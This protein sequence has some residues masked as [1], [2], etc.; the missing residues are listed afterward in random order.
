MS[1]GR[2]AIGVVLYASSPLCYAVVFS[3]AASIIIYELQSREV[4]IGDASIVIFLTGMLVV[5]LITLRL[6][7]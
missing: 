3:I 6:G 7:V 1:F 4:L 5:S 2:V